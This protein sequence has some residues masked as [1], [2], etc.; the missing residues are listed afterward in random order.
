MKNIKLVWNVL[1]HNSSSG[2]IVSYNVLDDDY[3][4]TTMKKLIKSGEIFTVAELKEFLGK[5]FRARY[6]SRAEYEIMVSGLF[7]EENAK[8]LDVWRQLEM[9][10]DSITDY[11]IYKLD[12]N[13]SNK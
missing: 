8:K 6:M 7:D 10:I 1:L 12:L 13:L 2:D 11:I 5:K 3:I 9:N 4:I